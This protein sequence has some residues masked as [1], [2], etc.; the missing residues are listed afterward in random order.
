MCKIST[1]RGSVL[2]LKLRGSERMRGEKGPQFCSLTYMLEKKTEQGLSKSATSLS[3]TEGKENRRE[4]S[5]MV[6]ARVHH[7]GARQL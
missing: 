3:S 5:V 7:R 6:K 2:I 1:S 4:S